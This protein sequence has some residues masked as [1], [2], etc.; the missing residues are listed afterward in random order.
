MTVAIQN[1]PF[2]SDIKLVQLWFKLFQKPN[3]QISSRFSNLKS[4]ILTEPVKGSLKKILS[5]NIDS[6]WDSHI[7]V[8]W[9]PGFLGFFGPVYETLI[10]QIVE[11]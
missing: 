3:S 9:I 1:S 6:I 5:Q 4:N 8:G 2:S 7:W 11:P 10:T